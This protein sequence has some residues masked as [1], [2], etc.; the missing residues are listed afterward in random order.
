[1]HYASVRKLMESIAA[2][3][4]AFYKDIVPP[5]AYGIHTESAKT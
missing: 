4:A 3:L 5:R 1:M 2:D